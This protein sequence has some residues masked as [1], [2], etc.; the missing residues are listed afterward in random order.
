MY[1]YLCIYVSMYA[2]LSISL[3]LCISLSLYV[4]IY[5]ER[6]TYIYTHSHLYGYPLVTIIIIIVKCWSPSYM[7]GSRRGLLF[8]RQGIVSFVSNSNVSTLRPVVICPYLCT[9]NCCLMRSIFCH[10]LRLLA[11]VCLLR[12]GV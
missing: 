9:P 6:E 8:Q 4:Y 1:M 11:R 3:S 12:C 7:P 5:I 10:Q 2:S